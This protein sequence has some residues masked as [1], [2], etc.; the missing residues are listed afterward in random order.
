MVIATQ[1]GQGSVWV[2]VSPDKNLGNEPALGRNGA[3]H[4]EF[5]MNLT[6]ELLQRIWHDESGQDL[7]EYALIATL[8]A[9]VAISG[10]NGL[11]TKIT[12]YY[13]GIGTDM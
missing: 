7:I 13:T 9:L 4:R 12:S 2:E 1:A 8:V 3:V 11:A 6:T 10:L 5:Q